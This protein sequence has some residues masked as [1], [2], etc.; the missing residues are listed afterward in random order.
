MAVFVKKSVFVFI[1]VSLLCCLHVSAQPRIKPLQ[2]PV[3]IKLN[4][5]GVR[6]LTV[7]DLATVSSDIA[8]TPNITIEPSWLTCADQG[9][10]TIKIKAEDASG[11]DSLNVQVNV[12]SP[13]KITYPQSGLF[14]VPGY[15][16]CLALLPDFSRLIKV[17]SYCDNKISVTQSIPPKTYVTFYQNDTTFV[18]VKAMDEYGSVDSV[19]L[20]VKAIAVHDPAIKISTIDTVIC[21][22]Q[23]ATFNMTFTGLNNELGWWAVNGIAM[24][25]A[26]QDTVTLR[27]LKNNDTV[28]YSTE[29]VC[30][31]LLTSNPIAISV[32]PVT[33]PVLHVAASQSV[34]CPFDTVT[35]TATPSY[36]VSNAQYSWHLNGRLTNV[37]SPLFTSS[38]L[39]D[40]DTISCTMQG[41]TSCSGFFTVFSDNI[42]VHVSPVVVPKISVSPGDTSIC[43]GV[44]QLIFKASS[45]S[46]IPGTAYQWEINENATGADSPVYADDNL[47]DGDIIDCVVTI[48]GSCSPP[49]KS[50]S[51]HITLSAVPH[52]SFPQG[53][54]VKSGNSVKLNPII[55]G[56]IKAYQWTPSAGLSD[57]TSAS[58]MASPLKTTA[59][60]LTVESTDNCESSAEVTVTVVNSLNIPSAFTPNGDGINDKWDLIGILAYPNCRVQVYDRYG[61]LVFYSKGYSSAWEGSFRGN[62]L[63]IGVY[64]FIIHPDSHSEPLSGSV[65]ILR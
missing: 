18:T 52:I 30:G 23:T 19:N 34:I 2:G 53:L 50:N 7:G 36:P 48:P 31:G 24:P 13:I 26:Y 63:P 49:I 17:K 61:R 44:N 60:T 9:V 22:G 56:D 21:T 62:P 37:K 39:K 64:Y 15:Y 32:T 20:K 10:K 45:G 27:N 28:T 35:Y 12:I 5:S 59:Y 3:I 51:S 57:S 29:T 11:A 41:S 4:T 47:H 46:K 6:K 33:P 16:G 54:V 40:G 58:P 1:A 25:G 42:L 43:A 65:A 14:L 38:E 8:A 55:T